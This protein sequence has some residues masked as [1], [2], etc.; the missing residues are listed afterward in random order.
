MIE[1]FF[2]E[3]EGPDRDWNDNY[4]PYEDEDRETLFFDSKWSQESIQTLDRVVALRQD[5]FI[6]LTLS[7]STS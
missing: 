6:G 2:T 3:M 4:E 5:I 1:Q 7:T